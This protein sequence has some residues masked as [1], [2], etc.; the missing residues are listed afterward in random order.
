M[1]VLMATDGSVC[2]D[3]AVEF[4]R[5]FPLPRDTEVHLVTVIDKEVYE[6]A[7]N[8]DLSAERRQLLDQTRQI[9]RED[10]GKLLDSVSARLSDRVPPKSTLVR[11]GQPAEEI[12][13]AA[14]EIGA[15]LVVVGSHGLGTVK[16]FLLGS[17]SNKVLRYAHCSVL[18][19]KSVDCFKDAG[20]GSPDQATVQRSARQSLV[21]RVRGCEA[22][23]VS[24][25][26][27]VDRGRIA[28]TCD[29]ESGPDLVLLLPVDS[30]RVVRGG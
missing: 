4:L 17:V 20:A 19:A 28:P 5:V 25:V 21:A 1:R 9:L 10:A 29:S 24:R 11:S 8:K 23:R 12:I 2:S 6:T 22:K 3:S 30:H 7:D 26:P 13:D 16:R 27:T 14:R 15:N 18:I